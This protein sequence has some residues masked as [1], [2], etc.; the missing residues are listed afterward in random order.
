MKARV[1]QIKRIG[2]VSLEVLLGFFVLAMLYVVCNAPKSQ[3]SPTKAPLAGAHNS[4][5]SISKTLLPGRG[6]AFDVCIQDDSNPQNVLQFSS[7]TGDY[8]FCCN[9]LS[10]SGV[11]GITTKGGIITLFNGQGDS[12]V[13][14]QIDLS[15]NKGKASLQFPVGSTVCAFGD[16]NTTNN[17]CSCGGGGG[18]E[19][20]K[21]Q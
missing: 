13:L 10:V 18:T 12:R 20:S 14:G 6:T 9:G 16:R 17:T 2:G 3:A 21:S 15:V 19:F 4:L 8:T 11:G 7:T 1:D 5:G